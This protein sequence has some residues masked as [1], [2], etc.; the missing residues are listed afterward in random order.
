MNHALKQP[1][2]NYQQLAD[3]MI[4][5]AI[6]LKEIDDPEKKFESYRKSFL[7][8]KHLDHHMLQY[9]RSRKEVAFQLIAKECNN[10]RECIRTLRW[11]IDDVLNSIKKL[12]GITESVQVQFLAAE[13]GDLEVL[14]L[15]NEIGYPLEFEKIA[16]TATLE[17][18]LAIL[19]W[20]FL[21]TGHIYD[22]TRVAALLVKDL[23]IDEYLTNGNL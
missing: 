6:Q 20:T 12:Y 8:I 14:I 2:P 5:V 1:P 9:A 13:H 3:R 10:I 17:K 7:E 16:E 4:A 23:V 21:I 19:H 22:S 18:Q 15:L 11:S